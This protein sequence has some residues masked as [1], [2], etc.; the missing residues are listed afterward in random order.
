MINKYYLPLRPRIRRKPAARQTNMYPA[1]RCTVNQTYLMSAA[2]ELP[3][4]YR[5]GSLAQ[6]K[7]LQKGYIRRVRRSRYISN[8]LPVRNEVR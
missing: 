3:Q 8:G 6:E 5:D 2:S 1:V 7:K 4:I